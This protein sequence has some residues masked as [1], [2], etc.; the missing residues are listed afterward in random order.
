[1]SRAGPNRIGPGP[2]LS[3]SRNPR[4]AENGKH[5]G[6]SVGDD[7]GSQA[8]KRGRDGTAGQDQAAEKCANLQLFREWSGAGWPSAVKKNAVRFPNAL[9][10]ETT[11]LASS[12]GCR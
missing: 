9:E 6:S 7:D 2:I 8:H 10:G 11:H 3:P 4:L 5:G 1:M 12:S